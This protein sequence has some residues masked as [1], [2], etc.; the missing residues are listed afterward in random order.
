MQC[1]KFHRILVTVVSCLDKSFFFKSTIITSS[2]GIGNHFTTCARI[3]DT[4]VVTGDEDASLDCLIP[5][6]S[7]STTAL[8]SMF[9]VGRTTDVAHQRICSKM[10]KNINVVWLTVLILLHDGLCYRQFGNVV[11]A[12]FYHCRLSLLVEVFVS[13][14]VFCISMKKNYQMTTH[15]IIST[16]T[17]WNNEEVFEQFFR[18]AQ[19]HPTELKQQRNNCICFEIKCRLTTV[20]DLFAFYWVPHFLDILAPSRRPLT[21]DVAIGILPGEASL[22]KRLAGVVFTYIHCQ[23]VKV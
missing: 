1:S 2:I 12:Q 19:F 8:V 21:T 9:L 18:L 7:E 22:K 20:E 16:F 23:K 14:H 17:I 3:F 15:T 4:D 10:S 6:V 11:D 13:L 5:R